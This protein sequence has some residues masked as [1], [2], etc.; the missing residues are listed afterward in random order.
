M[1]YKN[2][3]ANPEKLPSF[4]PKREMINLK[5][6]MTQPAITCSKITIETLEHYR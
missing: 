4:R 5:Y 3:L 2:V 6:P 1:V